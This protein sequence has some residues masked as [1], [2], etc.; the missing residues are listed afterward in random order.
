M[1]LHLGAHRTATTLIQRTVRA[2]REWLTSKHVR[3]YVL[4]DELCWR[5]RSY[6]NCLNGKGNE[7]SLRSY[8]EDQLG[9]SHEKVIISDEN[10]MGQATGVPPRHLYGDNAAQIRTLA[11][12]FGDRQVKVLFYLRDTSDF[13]GSCYSKYL[14]QM[15]SCGKRAQSFSDYL[16]ETLTYSRF[17][18]R[19]VLRDLTEAFGRENVLLGR[20]EWIREGVRE[21]VSGFLKAMDIEVDA[22]EFHIP[23]GRLNPSPSRLTIQIAANLQSLGFSSVSRAAMRCLRAMDSWLRLPGVRPVPANLALCLRRQYEEDLKCIWR[24]TDHSYDLLPKSMSHDLG[25]VLG[26]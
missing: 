26:G 19:P 17:S 18:W 4:G 1:Y 20:Y 9:G 8:L 2:N 10:I 7:K 22:E 23:A 16:G 11:D 24:T 15:L 5:I 21:Y 12:L 25:S 6:V 13:I 14:G 3:A